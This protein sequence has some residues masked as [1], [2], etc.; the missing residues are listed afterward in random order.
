M[1]EPRFK[2]KELRTHRTG[3]KCPDCGHYAHTEDQYNQ[4]RA[5]AQHVAPTARVPRDWSAPW[6]KGNA[7]VSR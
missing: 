4:H 2:V 3:F 6:M 5:I 1:R 7:N